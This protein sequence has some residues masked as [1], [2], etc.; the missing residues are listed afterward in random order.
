MYGLPTG[1]LLLVQLMI[2]N[3][4]KPRLLIGVAIAGFVLGVIALVAGQMT[5]GPLLLFIG[6]FC[7]ILAAILITTPQQVVAEAMA[8]LPSPGSAKIVESTEPRA[9]DRA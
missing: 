4:L 9:D 6:T 3:L 7:T 1:A 2:I 5:L 8:A